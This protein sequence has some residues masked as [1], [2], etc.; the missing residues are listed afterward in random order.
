MYISHKA[1]DH[2]RVVIVGVLMVI[3][4]AALALMYLPVQRTPAINTAIV[5]VIIPYPGAQPTEVEEDITRKIE[6]ALQGLDNVDYIGSTSMRGSSVTN[7]VFLEGV[8][9]KRARDDVAHLVDQV[10]RELQPLGREVEP[11]ITDIDFESFPIM[12]VNLAGPE[13]FDQRALKQIAEDVQDELEAIPGV[14]N[15]QIFG[16]RERE[17]HVNINP[18]LFVEYGLSLGDIRRALANFHTAL[19]GGSLNT[20]EFDFQVRS[21]TRFRNVDD[22]RQVVV[23][24]RGGGLIRIEDIAEVRDTYQR[25]KNVAQLD[26]KNTATIIVNKEPNINTLGTAR[27]IKDRVAELQEQ[28]PHIEFSTTRDISEDIS[29]MLWVLGSS[30]VVGAMLVLVVLAWSMGLRISI[31]VLS[32]VPFSTAIALIFL[33]AAQIPISNLVIFSFILVL[34]MVVDG[35]IIV[36]ENIHRHIERG[37]SPE[38]AAKTGID[39]VGVPVIAADLTTIAA[40]LPMLLVPGIMGDFL[41]V[42]PKVVSVALFGSIIVDHLLIPAVA[43]RWYRRREPQSEAPASP[44]RQPH[45]AHPHSRIRPNHGVFTRSYAALLRYC[46]KNPWVVFGCCACMIVWAV[47]TFRHIGFTFF[48]ESDRAQFEVNFELPLGYSIEETLKAST[49]ITDPLLDLQDK[50][51]VVHFV[52][53]VGSSSGLASRLD[54]DPVTGPEFGKVM[55]QLTQP[56]TRKR[57][58]NRIIEELRSKIRPYPGMI[59]RVEELKEGP[60]GGAAV[61][62]RLSGKDLEQLGRLGRAIAARLA[63]VPGTIEVQTDYRPDSPEFVVEPNPDMVGQFDLTDIEVARLVQTAVLGDTTIE[64]TMDDEDV[65]LRLQADPE[66]QKHKDDITRLMLTSPTGRRARLGQLAEVRRGTGLFAVNRRDRRR[67]VTVRCNLRKDTGVIPDDV[68]KVLREEILPDF[69]LRVVEGNNMAFIGSSASDSEG[70]RAEFTGEN[71]ERDKNNRYLAR[72]MIVGVILIFAILVVQFNSFRQTAVVLATVPLS[73][74]GVIFGMWVCGHPFSMAS[75]I[76]L[77]CLAG[78]V[79]NDAIVLVDFANQARRRGMHVKHAILEAGVNRLRPVILTTVTTIGGLLP[80]F[81]NFS[82]GAEFW[83]PLTGAVIFGLAFATVLTLVVI[84]V[85]YSLVYR[86][87]N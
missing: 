59:H 54:T 62:V 39:E 44:A 18:D 2:P 45:P 10:R 27:A 85:C 6:D 38:V 75:F 8:E 53:A 41:G 80:L 86:R 79:V 47:A 1:I 13:G 52:T 70:T 51:E 34:G 15:T 35:A 76:G 58:Q 57:H 25:L 29:V 65:T 72:S 14:A 48:P 11:I 22:I 28:Y 32:A 33:F 12:L 3:A 19:P 60:P 36:A 30:A 17:I 78:I 67:T 23:G 68:F 40:F 61:M 83:G 66:Y 71:E 46:L 50:G 16:G 87:A 73:F 5:L 77:I 31:L 20:A 81:L 55:V 74:I 69:G 63:D 42:M 26:G 43:A 49:A 4:M 56:T 82:G 9:A 84:P 7:I 37:E 24:K 64:L 21:E